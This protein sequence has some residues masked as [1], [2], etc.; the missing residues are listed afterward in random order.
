LRVE[1]EIRPD[2]LEAR[3]PNLLL[4]PLVENAIRHGIAPRQKG[5]RVTVSAA[6][7]DGR[8]LLTVEDDG[9]GIRKGDPIRKG[10]QREGVGLRN[11]R[12]RLERMYPQ[13]HEMTI[14][15]PSTGGFRVRIEIPFSVVPAGNGA[16]GASVRT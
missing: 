16:G 11:T 5:G 9:A 10:N 3:V 12:A 14:E 6:R 13:S 4:Q 2:A 15:Q 7:D 8:L 1:L